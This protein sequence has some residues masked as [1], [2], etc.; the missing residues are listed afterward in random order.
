QEGRSAGAEDLECLRERLPFGER[1]EVERLGNENAEG[2]RRL[3]RT[4][5]RERNLGDVRSEIELAGV[6]P[7]RTGSE[8]EDDGHGFSRVDSKR[9]AGD[10]VVLA[11]GESGRADQRSRSGVSKGQRTERRV[12]DGHGAEVEGGRG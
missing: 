3:E 5:P 10:Q 6:R 7:D 2:A 4:R 1:P 11:T 8:R 12:T 9:P